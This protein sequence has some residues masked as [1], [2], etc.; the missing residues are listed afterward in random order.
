MIKHQD[1]LLLIRHS[2]EHVPSTDMQREAYERYSDYSKLCVLHKEMVFGDSVGKDNN[3]IIELKSIIKTHPYVR[4]VVFRRVLLSYRSKILRCLHKHKNIIALKGRDVQRWWIQERMKALRRKAIVSKKYRE[5]HPRVRVSSDKDVILTD[6]LGLPILGQR[7]RGIIDFAYER[8]VK[9]AIAKRAKLKART[10]RL[11]IVKREKIEAFQNKYRADKYKAIYQFVLWH[12][13]IED[14]L[15][16]KG[17]FDNVFSFVVNSKY[18]S[19]IFNTTDR[20][21]RVLL[22]NTDPLPEKTR[23]EF[24]AVI[25]KD[26]ENIIYGYNKKKKRLR[27]D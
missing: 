18:S 14:I 24:L 17:V 19:Q 2:S 8:K 10:E 5:A 9:K 12:S 21:K 1:V 15:C 25:E 7:L 22:Y 27:K 20:L 13:P 6:I 3:N 16:K 23:R 11:E 4:I 26:K